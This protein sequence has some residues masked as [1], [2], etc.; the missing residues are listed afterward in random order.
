MSNWVGS[1]FPKAETITIP[2]H[3][4]HCKTSSSFWSAVGVIM[5]VAKTS[6][7]VAEQRAPCCGFEHSF[8]LSVSCSPFQVVAKRS[9]SPLGLSV[10]GWT[11]ESEAE[12]DD[13]SRPGRKKL[14]LSLSKKGKCRAQ[15]Q[16]NSERFE[17]ISGAKVETLGKKFVPQKHRKF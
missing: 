11:S 6:I 9:Q 8:L 5:I 2:Y 3:E 14:K 1:V 12:N 10:E 13:R 7:A 17:L 15:D 4:Y 16:E